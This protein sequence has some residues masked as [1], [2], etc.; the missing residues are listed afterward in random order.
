MLWRCNWLIWKKS[1]RCINSFAIGWIFLQMLTIRNRWL[2]TTAVARQD[3]VDKVLFLRDQLKP[4]KDSHHFSQ[5][6]T[7]AATGT[8]GMSRRR[9]L[10]TRKLC[11]KIFLRKFISHFRLKVGDL[12][13]VYT[14]QLTFTFLAYKITQTVFFVTWYGV[15]SFFQQKN[16]SLLQNFIFLYL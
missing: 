8:A 4:V 15:H 2:C 6:V 14:V 12:L 16:Q 5:R 10:T 3:Q 11:F 1:Q 13:V 7:A 9:K